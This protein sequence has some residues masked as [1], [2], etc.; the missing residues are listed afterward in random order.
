MN[1]V[2]YSPVFV[3]FLI[4]SDPMRKIPSRA[5]RVDHNLDKVLAGAIL[6]LDRRL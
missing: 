2:N 4:V 6:G 5:P 3:L 1:R